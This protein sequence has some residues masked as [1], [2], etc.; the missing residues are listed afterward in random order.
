MSVLPPV[1]SQDPKTD[2]KAPARF[3]I[4]TLSYN[5][6]GLIT[7]FLFLLWGDFCFSLMELVVPTI[8][9]LKVNSLQAPNWLLGL[10][11]TTI[12]NLMG[13]III[14]IISFRSDRFRSKWGRR[15]PFLIGATPF[16]VLFL[17]LL[18]YAEPIARWVHAGVLGGKF[19]ETTV[20]LAAIGVFMVCF[21]FFNLFITSVYYYLFND[22]VPSA[23][24]ARF[25]ALFKM[26]G[27]AAGAGYNFFVL[28]HANTHMQEIFLIAGILYLIAFVTMC[29][30]VKE[31]EY[32]PPPA[33]V[34]NGGGIMAAIK[35][36]ASECFTHRFYWIFFL[37]NTCVAMTWATQVYGLIFGTKYMGFDLGLIGKVSAVSGLIGIALLYPAGMLADR[38][39]PLRMLLAGIAAQVLMGLVWMVFAFMR[40]QVT[41]HTAISI[42]MVLCAVGLPLNA[43]YGASELPTLM[44]LLPRERYGQFC[45]ANAMVRSIALIFAGIACGA[46]LDLAKRL[47]PD[48]VYCYRFISVWNLFFNSCAAFFFFL[49]YREWKR[50]GGMHGFV[51]PQV[52]HPDANAADPQG[53]S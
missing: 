48:P 47:N 49:L 15:I 34:G 18:G 46:F 7:L 13:A 8:L 42:W 53:E 10:I 41:L 1:A 22:V 51:P 37:A 2:R 25:M 35:T 39:H 40:H 23:L 27:G 31:G 9:P 11:M 20:L 16:L 38:F 52:E 12:P 21:Q 4:G 45:S 28:K 24:L 14:P 30:K 26:V 44:K 33:Y 32:P 50:L 5:K 43:L 19:S 6:A 29:W 3:E 36:Y 17:V